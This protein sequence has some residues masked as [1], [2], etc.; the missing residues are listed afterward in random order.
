MGKPLN[1][2]PSR[3]LNF[4]ARVIAS[5]QWSP[6]ETAGWFDKKQ[7]IVVAWRARQ[8]WGFR[9]RPIGSGLL[10]MTGCLREFRVL[11]LRAE[12]QLLYTGAYACV[13]RKSMKTGIHPEYPEVTVSCACGNTFKTR[14]THKGD[15]RLEICSNCHPFFTGKQRLVDTAGRVERFNRKYG[16]R[17]S[18]GS[19][20]ESTVGSTAAVEKS[21]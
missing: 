4:A 6:V 11:P 3:K 17:R 5:L 7:I 21:S 19:A 14:S 1:G 18:T 9:E 13:Q 20:K 15:I 10:P 8:L 12:E 2:L 16:L